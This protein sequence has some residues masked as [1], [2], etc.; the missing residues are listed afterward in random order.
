MNFNLKGIIFIYSKRVNLYLKEV[1][2]II[3]LNLKGIIL[4]YLK[5]VNLYLKKSPFNN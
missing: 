1:S 3:N 4:I 2:L 5:K